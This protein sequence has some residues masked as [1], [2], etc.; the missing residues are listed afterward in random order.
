MILSGR[1]F[2]CCYKIIAFSLAF[3]RAVSGAFSRSG[4]NPRFRAAMLSS[5]GAAMLIP[6]QTRPTSITHVPDDYLPPLF[7]KER[8]RVLTQDASLEEGDCV[9]YWMQRDVRVA[10]N[11]ALLLAAHVASLKRVP[12]KVVY[13]LV[14]P[15]VESSSSGTEH[16]DEIPPLVNLKSTMRYA[17]FLL[18]GL[19]CVHQE[20]KAMNVP[21]HIVQ[22]PSHETVGMTV[23]QHF[24]DASLVVADFGPLRHFR[25]WMEVQTPRHYKG[26]LWQVDAHNVVPV[27]QAAESRQVGARTLRPKLHKVLDKYLQEFPAV[28]VDPT[29]Q[30]AIRVPPFDRTQYLSYLQPDESVQ[31]VAWAKPG[32]RAALNQFDAFVSKGLK[33]YDTLRNDPTHPDVCSNLSPWINHGHVSF[34]RIALLTRQHNK[35]ASGTASFL[36]EGIV[37]REL[38]D[39]F[40]YYTPNDYDALTGAAS[41]AQD[42]LQLHASDVRE[43]LYSTQQLERGETH[44]DLWN[45][46][47][48]QVVRE[49]RMHGFLRMYWAKKIVE[50]TASPEVA[51]HT[52]QYFNDKYALDGRDPNGFVGVGWSVMGIHDMGW[53]EREIFGKIRYMNYNGCKRKFN[54]AAF[55]SQY[56]GAVWNAQQAAAKL[57]KTE[58]AP[59]KRLATTKTPAEK[60]TKKLKK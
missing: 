23:A 41:W 8:T 60:A 40:C 47:Q 29:I 42:S 35:Y 18:G 46:A 59:V 58:T 25:E 54:V 34:Q 52:A 24:G 12:L 39:N 44:D 7:L 50:W 37:R 19:E 1:C 10:D 53:K 22:S 49:G 17:D 36:E 20:L 26:A 30:A 5:R 21:L 3:R 48:L 31:P 28:H 56:K 2:C 38:S 55:V 9:W 32:T 13:A 45:A 14:P 51:L 27:W 57:K 15:P 6:P 4:P 11:S 16:D 33:L 43:H